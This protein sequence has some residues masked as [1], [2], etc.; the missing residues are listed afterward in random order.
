MATTTSVVL[1][2]GTAREG[3]P[4][5]ARLPA[6][7]SPSSPRTS[8]SALT[9]ASA[10]TTRASRLA[11]AVPMP[12]LTANAG[13]GSLAT[14]APVPAPTLPSATGPSVAAS[15]AAAPSSGPGRAAGSPTPRSNRIAAGTIG[16]RAGPASNPIPRESSHRATPSAA[17]SPNALPPVSTTAWTSSTRVPGRSASVSRVPGAPPRTSTD[18]TVPGGHR[19]TVQP[20]MP[21]RSVAWPTRM[22]ATSVID[23]AGSNEK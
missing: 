1:V 2:L 5:A 20:V 15:H 6:R 16:T 9:A 8:P 17:A 3:V 19:T 11:A 4:G 22:P 7:I 13:S 12:P 23:P 21:A 18:P 10:P 14:V